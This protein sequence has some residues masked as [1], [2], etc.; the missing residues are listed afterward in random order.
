MRDFVKLKQEVVYTILI[1]WQLNVNKNFNIFFF[2]RCERFV[3]ARSNIFSRKRWKWLLISLRWWYA[4]SQ[5]TVWCSLLIEWDTRLWFYLL[6]DLY[7]EMW[8]TWLTLILIRSDYLL[9][10]L[11]RLIKSFKHTLQSLW[12]W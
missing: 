6:C 4:S 3:N 10:C 12:K 8:I 1:E 2:T 9:I 7:V 5:Y 11:V